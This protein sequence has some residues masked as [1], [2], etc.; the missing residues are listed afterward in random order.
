MRSRSVSPQPN[1]MGD[2][3]F[4]FPVAKKGK[5]LRTVVFL[6]VTNKFICAHFTELSAGFRLLHH[7][8][9]YV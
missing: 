6:N 4:Q 3:K 8:D 7:Y 1:L 9:F 2:L 5:T